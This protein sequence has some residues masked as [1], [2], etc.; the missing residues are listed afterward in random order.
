MY[1]N[2]NSKN[3]RNSNFVLKYKIKINEGDESNE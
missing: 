3:F 2:G 1:V